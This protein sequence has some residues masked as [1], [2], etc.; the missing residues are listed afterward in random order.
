M[1]GSRLERARLDCLLMHKFEFRQPESLA[2]AF[3]LLED[4]GADAVMLAGGTDLT[5]ELRHGSRSPDVVIDIKRLVDVE[6]G[7]K[8]EDGILIISASTVITDIVGDETVQQTFP[9]LV[10]A[11]LVVGS[12]Q[13]RNRA[14][15]AG[16]ICNASPAADTVPA[17]AAYQASVTIASRHGRRQV[18]VAEFIL[19]NRQIDLATGEIVVA[20]NL[21]I[22]GVA[23]GSAFERI[24]RRRGVDLA[25]INLCC[26]VDADDNL[27][28]ALG[29]AAPRP[30]VV[31]ESGSELIHALRNGTPTS[32]IIDQLLAGAKP[33]SDIRA[34]AEYRFEMFRVIAD[35]AIRKAVA[36]LD[37]TS[38]GH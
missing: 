4:H 27:T 19:G 9:A 5:V 31:S 18:P 8:N 33:I 12:E 32:A 22:P 21:P 24:A 10:E 25:T 26:F 30:F 7:L 13:I 23:T 16:N 11:A 2:D 3:A 17:L 15:L 1:W 38:A 28:Y 37:A 34:S 36:R 14:T 35:R 29:A 20:V 6:P